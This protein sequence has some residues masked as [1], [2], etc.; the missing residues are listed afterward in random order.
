MLLAKVDQGIAEFHAQPDANTAGTVPRPILI[1]HEGED[2]DRSVVEIT[3]G[4][5]GDTLERLWPGDLARN[6]AAE[7]LK[8]GCRDLGHGG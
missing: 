7:F 1:D 3:T 6:V 5:D 2:I 4:L 8:V